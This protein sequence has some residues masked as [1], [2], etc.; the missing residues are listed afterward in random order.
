MTKILLA[1][2][3]SA[4]IAQAPVVRRISSP[5]LHSVSGFMMRVGPTL[6]P[7]PVSIILPSLTTIGVPQLA[8]DLGHAIAVPAPI[9]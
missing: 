1:F 9:Q 6:S 4:T 7:V 5:A 8:L 3:S 2:E